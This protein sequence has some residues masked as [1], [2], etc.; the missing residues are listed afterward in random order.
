ME[1][2]KES[3]LENCQ[4]QGVAPNGQF[5]EQTDQCISSGIATLDLN[6]DG[7]KYYEKL[8]DKDL[9]VILDTLSQV[10]CIHSI[11]VPRNNL[12]DE[13]LPKLGKLIQQSDSIISI[14]LSANQFSSNGMR[15]LQ[16]AISQSQS[17]CEFNVSQNL[18]GD[19]G[20]V[21][22]ILA[23]RVNRTLTN[24]DLSDTNINSNALTILGATLS[25]VQR[26]NVLK[27]DNPHTLPYPDVAAKRLLIS[28]QA[29]K[30]LNRFI[31]CKVMSH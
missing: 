7:G 6:I 29:N 10:G 9:L 15:L 11:S 20:C 31:I 21:F 24:V 16:E 23:L 27:V 8:E 12:T 18:I 17:L 26:L 1:K 5:I 28:L 3:Y 25:E 2:L 13:V 19:E 22:I 4:S 14:N 30:K